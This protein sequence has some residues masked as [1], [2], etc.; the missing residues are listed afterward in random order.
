VLDLTFV[1]EMTTFIVITARSVQGTTPTT[2]TAS[3]PFLRP[4]LVCHIIDTTNR[5]T[6][7]GI[8]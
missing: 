8:I 3:Y 2:T 5:A 7:P 4:R 6:E 1:S